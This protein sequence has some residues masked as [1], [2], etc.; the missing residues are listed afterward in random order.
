MDL[1]SWQRVVSE[2]FNQGVVL[3]VETVRDWSQSRVIRLKLQTG[4]K[5]KVLYAKQAHLGLEQECALYSL[6]AITPGFPA[7]RGSKVL[8]NGEAWLLLEAALGTRLC[9]TSPECYVRA[10]EYLAEYHEK[11]AQANWA[12][13]LGLSDKLAGIPAVASGIAPKLKN[14]VNS[15]QFSG[16]DLELLDRVTLALAREQ[17][18][19]SHLPVTLA[20]GDCHNGNVFLSPWGIHLIDWGSAARAPG[21]LDIVGLV[22]VALRMQN[23]LGC[24]D[25]LLRGY[26]SCLSSATRRQYKSLDDACRLMRI[27]RALLEL[28]WFAGTR[29]DYGSRANRELL[30]LNE[31]LA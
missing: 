28:E 8:V 24:V 22:D 4:S 10:V 27:V 23:D 14:L 5:V 2:R 12:E 31:C 1:T 21:L 17:L 9:D 15:G 3:A 25:G 30:I 16:L 26:W 19:L 29:E 20:H 11:A 18:A 13:A 6:A 7:P